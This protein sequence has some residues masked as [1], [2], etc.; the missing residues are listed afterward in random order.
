ME[1][2]NLVFSQVLVPEGTDFAEIIIV[3]VIPASADI[4]ENTAFASV[5]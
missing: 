4:F 5:L 3:Y 1:T 2:L